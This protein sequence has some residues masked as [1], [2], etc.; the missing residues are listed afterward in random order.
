VC[1]ARPIPKWPTKWPKW[2]LIFAALAGLLV[3]SAGCGN[4]RTG[5]PRWDDDGSPAGSVRVVIAPLNLGVRLAR[6]LEEA[7]EPVE[8]EIIRYFQSNGARV[9]IIWPDDARWLWQELMTAIEGSGSHAPNLETAGGAFVRALGEHED[10]DL[11]V[12]PSLVYRKARVTGR[13]AH[14][15]GVRRR[16]TVHARTIAGENFHTRDWRGRITALSLHALV[17]TPEGHRVFEGCGGIDLVHDAVLVD[18]GS[19]ERSF[20]R[21]QQQLIENPEHVREGVA[22]ALEQEL[23]TRP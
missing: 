10:F 18:E 6:D 13:H 14:W 21:L 20:L 23:S 12:M 9:A 16:V 1:I 3:S 17:F 5:L 8:T 19:S 4:V 15:D 2:G 22:L 7:V 11:L